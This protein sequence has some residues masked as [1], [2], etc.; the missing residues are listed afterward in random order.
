M[1]N[2]YA[3]Y[4]G[5]DYLRIRGYW[6]PWYTKEFNEQHDAVWWIKQRAKQIEDFL[7][8]PNLGDYHIIDIGGD[9]GAIAE[10]MK[11]ASFQ[12]V[13][14]SESRVLDSSTQ[15]KSAKTVALCSHVLEHVSDPLAFIRQSLEQWKV[16][17][18]EV[19]D[20]VPEITKERR[21]LRHLFVGLMNSFFSARWR[22]IGGPAAGR[23]P[24]GQPL[25]QSE[26]LTFFTEKT[27][28]CLTAGLGSMDC[29]VRVSSSQ[30]LGPDKEPVRILQC[31]FSAQD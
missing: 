13:E 6:E 15:S 23:K 30:I 31:L 10:A 4:R 20:G 19:P 29:K 22:Q 9:T 21:S 17:Y 8:L 1:K 27:I 3:N 26:H 16:L 25:R 24:K 7:Q 28:R 12:V 18:V 11:P 14:I 2:L 5:E